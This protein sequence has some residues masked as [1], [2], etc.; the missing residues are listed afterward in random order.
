MFTR[1]IQLDVPIGVNG[2][3]TL[4]TSTCSYYEY[5]VNNTV[6]FILVSRICV[7]IGLFVSIDKKIW[8]SVYKGQA[9][10]WI[11][12]S[13]LQSLIFLYIVSVSGDSKTVGKKVSSKLWNMKI[14]NT[15]KPLLFYYWKVFKLKN[16]D[17]IVK[18]FQVQK[19]DIR[20][21]LIA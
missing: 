8:S 2:H 14:R 5:F 9:N 4:C 21:I 16:I 12:K 19:K 3:W 11:I 20:S 10:I 1:T 13:C 6:G 15:P 17:Q 7:T 18:D